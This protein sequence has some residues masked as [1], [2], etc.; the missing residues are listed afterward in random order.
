MSYGGYQDQG[1][2]Y[3]NPYTSASNTEAGHGRGRQ[4]EQHELQTYQPGRYESYGQQQSYSNAP[5]ASQAYGDYSAPA[6]AARD[7]YGAGSDFFSNRARI[8]QQIEQLDHD[9]NDMS[10]LQEEARQSMDP[11]RE[12]QQI[13]ELTQR[14]RMTAQA[15]RSEL[16]TLTNEAGT[17]RGKQSH[18][19]SL[20][21]SL[22]AKVNRMLQAESSYNEHVRREMARQYQI[23]NPGVSDEEARAA[24]ADQSF[25]SGGIFQ[26]AVCIAR[27]PPS[28]KPQHVGAR[29]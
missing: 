7:G 23:V 8:A 11:T 28:P 2:P 19:N 12:Q 13:R 6:P 22:K 25:E 27:S 24:V 15:I 29:L 3:G 1:N 14:F 10:T 20:K 4:E 16:Q 18:V 26:Q 9:L 21:E 5:A 17:D